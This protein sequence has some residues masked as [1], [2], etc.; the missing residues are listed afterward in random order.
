MDVVQNFNELAIQVQEILAA[1]LALLEN[2]DRDAESIHTQ[3]NVARHLIHELRQ[4]AHDKVPR[5]IFQQHF[6]RCYD[7]ETNLIA[8]EDGLLSLPVRNQQATRA[9]ADRSPASIP[10]EDITNM[11]Y[12]DVQDVQMAQIFGCS[13]RTVARRRKQLG[14]ERRAATRRTTDEEVARVSL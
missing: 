2:P 11:F 10:A 3:L 13:A 5:G 1:P 7:I 6:Q 9:R 12:T 4:N 14:L 8:L